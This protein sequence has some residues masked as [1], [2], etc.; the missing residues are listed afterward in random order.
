MRLLPALLFWLLATAAAVAEDMTDDLLVRMRAADVVILGEVHDNAAHHDTQA[1]IVGA[2][3]PAAVVWEMLTTEQASRVP[4]DAAGMEASSLSEALEWQASGWPDF[5][6]YAPIFTAAGAARHY[7]AA[8]P[9]AAIREFLE[10]DPIAVFGADA[11]RWGL[12]DVLPADQLDAR[13]ALQWEAHCRALPEETLHP[14][15][16]IQRVRDAALAR[17]AVAALEE[18]GGPVI[19]ITGN[20]HARR[21]WGVPSYLSRVAPETKVFALGQTEDDAPLDGGYDAVLSAPAQPRG[22]P[23]EAFR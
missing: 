2:L 20:G 9:R 1:R 3:E 19:V 23:C 11:D 8:V 21:D 5:T 15:V 7:G 6:M 18:T 17:A 12:R 4:A 14:M 16:D 13:V 22:D 10:S